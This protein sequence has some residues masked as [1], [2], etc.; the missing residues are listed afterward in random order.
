M[1]FADRPGGGMEIR[2]VWFGAA[3]AWTESQT[4]IPYPGCNHINIDMATDPP[5]R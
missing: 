3:G 5:S 2:V 1:N 4:I